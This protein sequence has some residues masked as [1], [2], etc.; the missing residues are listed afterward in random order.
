[1][2]LAEKPRPPDVPPAAYGCGEYPAYIE[3]EAWEARR[4]TDQATEDRF[5]PATDAGTAHLYGGEVERY[6]IQQEI[7][8]LG[9]S[10]DEWESEVDCTLFARRFLRWVEAGCPTEKGRT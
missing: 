6:W 3:Y 4:E 2:R 8:L 5:S 7:S 9:K 10:L 1:V